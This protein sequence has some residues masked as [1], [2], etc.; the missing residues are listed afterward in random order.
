MASLKI[1]IASI[2]RSA[3]AVGFRRF[4]CLGSTKNGQ[5]FPETYGGVVLFA[6]YEKGGVGFFKNE[7]SSSNY[8]FP[9]ANS[10]ASFQGRVRKCSFFSFC[11]EFC[12]FQWLFLVPL[13]GG[14]WYMI[15]QL[16][17][18]TTHI[19]LIALAFWGVKNATYHLLG[20]PET[21][22]EW[23]GAVFQKGE[24]KR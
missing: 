10:L 5:I 14:R 16:A 2:A 24:K 11:S 20:E 21:I 9:G 12:F 8:Q 1:A 17:V 13:K 22:I 3:Q 4:R 7:M 23:E 19:P 6:P 15:P 18:Y